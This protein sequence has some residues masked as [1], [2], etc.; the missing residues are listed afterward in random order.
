MAGEQERGGVA[1]SPQVQ[2]GVFGQSGR[3]DCV[4]FDVAKPGT[5]AEMLKVAGGVHGC[6][7]AALLD[8]M[9][10][11]RGKGDS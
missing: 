1:R 2:D 11:P 9:Q 3:Q 7:I 5:L 10:K 6:I 8:E 4:V